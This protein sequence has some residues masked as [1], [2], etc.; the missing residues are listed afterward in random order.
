MLR[1]EIEFFSAG[2][3][4]WMRGDRR[5]MRGRLPRTGLLRRGL[6]ARCVARDESARSAELRR[7][8]RPRGSQC[9]LTRSS[10]S[11]DHA[12][13]DRDGYPFRKLVAE[14]V[15]CVR[16]AASAFVVEEH[17]VVVESTEDGSNHGDLEHVATA[18][19]E[20]TDRVPGNE[21]DQRVRQERR[22]RLGVERA[23]VDAMRPRPLARA[24]AR[25]LGC[26]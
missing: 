12:G 19:R 15:S 13:E 2:S 9:G 6:Q 11:I 8:L 24:A 20:P 26:A 18:S 16:D 23:T 5:V 7:S 25:K 4:R 22:L 3:L 1:V 10:A 17:V 14:A 21:L